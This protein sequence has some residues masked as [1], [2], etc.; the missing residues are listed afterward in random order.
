MT[1]EWLS[2]RL[3]KMYL[4]QIY[5]S[6][7]LLLSEK[8]LDPWRQFYDGILVAIGLSHYQQPKSKY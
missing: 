3:P 6:G 2:G 4:K 1:A 5:N 7:T 8:N